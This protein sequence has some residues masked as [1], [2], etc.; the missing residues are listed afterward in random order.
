M[1]KIPDRIMI[2]C[3]HPVSGINIHFQV[4]FADLGDLAANKRQVD[5][6]VKLYC[7]L[8]ALDIIPLY[9]REDRI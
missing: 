5:V 1:D 7:F 3:A 4:P 9:W 6:Y 8:I 2:T